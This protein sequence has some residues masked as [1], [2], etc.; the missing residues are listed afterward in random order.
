[1]ATQSISHQPSSATTSST[2]TTPYNDGE[3]RAPRPIEEEMEY[4]ETKDE[5]LIQPQENDLETTTIQ[6]VAA[7]PE[8]EVKEEQENTTEKSKDEHETIVNPETDKSFKPTGCHVV[9]LG[10]MSGTGKSALVEEFVSQINQKANETKMIFLAGKFSQINTGDP[11]SAISQALDSYL[12]QLYRTQDRQ[13][14]KPLRKRLAQLDITLESEMTEIL[15]DT[16]VPHLP[17]LLRKA[18]RTAENSGGEDASTI[19]SKHRQSMHQ[20]HDMNAIKFAF[21]NFIQALASEQEPLT[22]FLDDLQWA[23]AA[24]LELISALLLDKTLNSKNNGI[25]FIGAYRDNEVNNDDHEFAKLM[26]QVQDNAQATDRAE[27]VHSMRIANLSPDA[28]REFIAD[29]LDRN[30]DDDD[31]E[32]KLPIAQAVYAKTLGNIFVV[33]QALEELVRKNAIY[34]DVM[35]FAWQFGNVD[36]VDLEQFLSDDAVQMVQNKLQ[37]MSIPLQKALVVAAYTKSPFE[38]DLL[39]SLLNGVNDDT[40]QDLSMTKEE[41]AVAPEAPPPMNRV[42]DMSTLEKLMKRAFKEG[43]VL[44]HSESNSDGGRR[45]SITANSSSPGYKFA[46]DRIREAACLL[47]PE[48]AHRDRMLLDIAKVLLQKQEEQDR[49]EEDSDESGSEDRMIFTAVQHLNSISDDLTDPIELAQL[50]LKVAKLTLQKGAVQEAHRFLEGG[51]SCLERESSNGTSDNNTRTSCWERY[52]N[53]YDLILDLKNNYMETERTLGHTDKSIEVAEE[54]FE[55]AVTVADQKR[56][57][58]VY[59]NA[60]CDK[61]DKN[62]DMAVDASLEILK[63]KYGM[64]LPA[65]PTDG[66]VNRE[67]L[68]LRLALRNRSLLCLAKF[69]IA[70][71]STIS[72]TVDQHAGSKGVAASAASLEE[73]IARIK[74]TQLTVMDSIFA[75]RINL[76]TYAGYRILREALAEKLITRD[77]PIVICNLGAS[78]RSRGMY[79]E[80]F[81]FANA[82]L[83][84]SKRF[85]VDTGAVSTREDL[86]GRI[87]LY[88]ALVGLRLPFYEVIETFMD[89][90]K[91]L[92][93]AGESGSGLACGMLGI[94]AFYS[95][96]LPLN[97]LLEPKLLLFEEMAET[98]GQKPF[99]VTFSLFRQCLYNLQGGSKACAPNPAILKG[100]ATFDEEEVQQSFEGAIHNMNNRD[101]GIMRLMLAVIFGDETVMDEMLD[102]LDSYPIHDMPIGRQ[103]I[104]MCYSGLA[105]LILRQHS[106]KHSKWA[107]ESMKFFEKLS[108]VGSPNAQPV[109]ACLEA[110][111]KQTVG[112]YEVAIQSCG[113][114]GLLNL[115]ALMNERCGMMLMEGTQRQS[116][117][118][119]KLGGVLEG[120]SKRSQE[121]GKRQTEGDLTASEDYEEYFRSAIWCYH[122]WGAMG[123]VSQMESKYGFLSMAIYQKP[124]SHLSSLRKQTKALLSPPRIGDTSSLSS[125]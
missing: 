53:H 71:E 17:R 55:H 104:R 6:E 93:N 85:A 40:V 46:H 65:A 24:S 1:M 31:A 99:I 76:A 68:L 36:R 45:K 54:I 38:L 30:N 56:A 12:K 72:T 124:K 9:F 103:H 69:P 11:F 15:A 120:G 89:L 57:H 37:T 119:C 58:I 64:E 105:A 80:A 63:S 82:V 112:A 108:K 48:G 62:Y 67:R 110:L 60:V 83:D 87:T 97:S 18:S 49:G 111:K 3:V 88:G 21:I 101:I 70:G 10:G 23:D 61:N 78:F 2:T 32:S 117:Q 34:Y 92:L 109:F 39:L 14:L 13:R 19:L 25:L 77:I 121:P 107:K 123:K 102:R 75:K 95:S 81:S 8:A 50:N 7:V 125:F 16:L 79:E 29:A 74:V 28:I 26:K 100:G 90:S 41:G 35:C 73:W 98:L 116:N 91:S 47:V 42:M 122:D 33:K 84:L 96:S 20:G 113:N 118:W 66:Q 59:I 43:L 44:L 5:E 115:M 52:S 114:A 27:S 22:F 94:Y 106:Q 51:V 4:E 86:F